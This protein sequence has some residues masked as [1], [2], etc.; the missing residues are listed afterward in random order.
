M[1]PIGNIEA[2]QIRVYQFSTFTTFTDKENELSE[3]CKKKKA[4]K[5]DLL[6]AIASNRYRQIDLC[7]TDKDGVLKQRNTERYQTFMFENDVI[8]LALKDRG[9]L[10]ADKQL[11]DEVIFVEIARSHYE[12]LKQIINNGLT[13][14]DFANGQKIKKKYQFFTAG[15]GHVRK[16][17][18]ALIKTDFFER[19]K[20]ELLLGLEPE[21]IKLNVG[22]YLAYT[23][24]SLSSS[25]LPDKP[26]DIDRCLVVPDLKT[27]VTDWVKYIDIGDKDGQCYVRNVPT[28]YQLKSIE[29]IQTDGSGMFLPGELLSSCQIRGGFIKGAMF[30]FDFRKF[31]R[32]VANNTVITDAW[33]NIHDIEQEDIRFIFT[34]SQLK[35]R[36]KFNS[37][38]EYKTAFKDNDIRLSI[39]SYCNPANDTTQF[40]YQYLQTLPYNSDIQKLCEKAK[41]NISR[42][43]SDFDFVR[44]TLKL[45]A[46]DDTGKLSVNV[47]IGK[48]L[49]IYPNL[50]YDGYIQNRISKLI[51]RIKREYRGGKIPINGYYSYAAPD[52]YAFCEFLFQG[53]ANPKGIVPKNHIYNQYYDSKGS[54]KLICL[55]SPHLSNYEYGKRDLIQSETCREWFKY[56]RTDTVCSCHDLLSK[57]LQMDFDGDEILVCDDAALYNLAKDLPDVPLYYDMQKAGEQTISKE[58]IYDTLVKGFE[59]NVIGTVSHII[60]KLWNSPK[61]A[62][63]NPTPYDDEINVF[64]AFS[65]YAIDYPKTGKNLDLDD[66]KAL[67]DELA[68]KDSFEASD[69]KL[70][71]FF[72][73]A[74]NKKNRN[75]AENYTHSPMDRICK[76]I[77]KGTSRLDPLYFDNN[78]K[79]IFDYT[80][81]MCQ[82]KNTD[83]TAKYNVNR[84]SKKYE[85]LYQLLHTRKQTEK[86]KCSQIDKEQKQQN[87]DKTEKNTQ[88]DTFYYFCIREIKE[89]FT[90]SSGFFNEKLAV[91][92]MV[93]LEYRNSEFT[94]TS[95]EILWRCFGHII[96]NNLQQN[97]GNELVI[98]YRP[99]IAYKKAVEGDAELD[100]RIDEKFKQPSVEITAADMEFINNSLQRY[101]NGNEHKN[102]R[103]LLFVLFCLY[104][105]ALSRD[106]LDKEGFLI[107][108]QRKHFI[109]YN[110]R[111]QK[112]RRVKFNMNK[113][114]DI[115]GVKSYKG[116]F[117]RLNQTEGITIDE[118]K[119]KERFKIKFEL[120]NSHSD[121]LFTVSN[122]FTPITY[123]RAYMGGKTPDKCKVCGKDFIKTSNNQKTCSSKCSRELHKI[124]VLRTNKRMREEK[125]QAI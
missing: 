34:D 50:I 96:L 94:G 56:M 73:Y 53:Q 17:K 8:R 82:E 99:R 125:V 70:P 52:L 109:D 72:K 84:Y 112:K 100:R 121:A 43:Y 81:L 40:A 116:S 67:Y 63:D 58:T 90:N 120:P 21:N 55:R 85:R 93:D 4:Q 71:R 19:H 86:E 25:V 18:V 28:D 98:K 11:L 91:N 60:T 89:I 26:I 77:G 80:M 59:N 78:E 14:Y 87:T 95:K 2:K 42:L 101:K 97:V 102:D 103:E 57:T 9:I 107:V 45:T 117:D 62:K 118:D 66:Y 79:N 110:S 12:I 15:A 31:A 44:E 61:A 22:K 30:P 46:D 37:W 39:N 69:I 64:T 48:A 123:L 122:V 54:E 35:L 49:D 29:L 106:R 111:N 38:D 1:I 75:V 23:A 114:M 10:K 105:D 92:Y 88:F 76:Y 36:K 108:T 24:L 65:N 3:L 13:V 20:Q 113:I 68:P 74:K 83:G 104:K 6:S 27:T 119:Q 7:Y 124:N 16:L 115:A 33:G 41:S 5:S 32:E 47:L 51:R